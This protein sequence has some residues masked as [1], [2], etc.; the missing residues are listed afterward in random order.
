MS[1]ESEPR[2]LSS[3]VVA[4]GT[5]AVFAL[6]MFPLYWIVVTSLKKEIEIFRCRP[7][8]FPRS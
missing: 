4:I 8:S 6:M 2:R 7:P 1:G 3:V 5:L